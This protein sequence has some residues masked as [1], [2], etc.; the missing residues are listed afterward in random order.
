MTMRRTIATEL[1]EN[2]EKKMVRRLI[3][4]DDP[5]YNDKGLKIFQI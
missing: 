1:T 2:T 4:S 5:S 3:R